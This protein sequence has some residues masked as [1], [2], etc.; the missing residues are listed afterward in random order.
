[1][2][3]ALIS[4]G[5]LLLLSAGWIHLRELHLP[6]FLSETHLVLGIAATVPILI[7]NLG[8]FEILATKKRSPRYLEFKQEI[9]IPLCKNLDVSAAAFVSLSAGVAEEILF[10]GVLNTELASLTTPLI[11]FTASSA[12]FAVIHFGTQA[13]KYWSIVLLYFCIGLYFTYLVEES[14]S[15]VPAIVAHAFYNFVTMLYIRYWA[16]P[17][18]RT[19]L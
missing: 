9:I 4:E 7:F 1:M 5:F 6:L 12:L 16:I 13:P 8:I 2:K 19:G 17:R 10:R 3:L 18:D 14:G 15:L 11:G